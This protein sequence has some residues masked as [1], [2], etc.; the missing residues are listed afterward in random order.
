M[1]GTNDRRRSRPDAAHLADRYV[2]R[3]WTLQQV[4]DECGWSLEWVR[5]Q[6]LAAGVVMHSRARTDLG[7]EPLGPGALQELVERGLSTEEIASAAG[8]TVASVRDLMTRHGLVPVPVDPAENPEVRQVAFLYV[9]QDMTM[10]EVGAALGRTVAWVEHRL[11]QA[12]VP[13]RRGGTR[14][15]DLD[16]DQVRELLDA[17]VS[18][19]DIA[20]EVGRSVST[21]YTFLAARGWRPASV[22]PRRR[23]TLPPLDVDTIRRLYV[24][25][26]HTLVEVGEMLGCNERRVRDAMDRAGIS[27]RPRKARP[28]SLLTAETLTALYL[29]QGMSQAEIA[30]K[31]GCTASGVHAALIRHG[32][33]RRMW[34]GPPASFDLDAQALRELF[35]FQRLGDAEIAERYG[36]REWH[37]RDRRQRLGVNRFAN[38]PRP[39]AEELHRLYVEERHSMREVARAVNA[40]EPVTRQWVIEAGI[41]LRPRSSRADRR[42]LDAALL[43][44]LYEA[45]EWNAVEIAAEL[46][47]TAEL[48]R[49]SLHAHNIPVRR[50]GVGTRRV[51]SDA[52]R[53]AEL[54]ADPEVIELL[55]VHAIPTRPQPGSIAERFPT[56]ILPTRALLHD[57]YEVIG[58]SAHHLELLTG[59]PGEQ[60]LDALHEEELEVRAPTGPS[61]WLRRVRDTEARST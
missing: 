6:L 31:L 16:P 56:P 24:D 59:Y 11:T 28:R 15:R 5:R 43:R 36:V 21:V 2:T 38:P 39:T 20:Q 51:D 60:I 48:V 13:R 17:G 34:G 33:Q 1:S 55:R 14:T 12:G 53:L 37:V 27:R 30:D 46:D 49:R 29:D 32:I 35:V 23:P 47:C 44:E 40:S 19:V 9:E 18:V 4:A 7:R 41:A 42:T 26:K 3:G 8:Y 52:A 57:G 22:P 61:P 50:A 25:E 58:L 45:R 10:V 54:Y